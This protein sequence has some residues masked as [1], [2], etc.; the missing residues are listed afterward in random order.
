MHLKLKSMV[1]MINFSLQPYDFGI[2]CW[3]VHQSQHLLHPPALPQVQGDQ[4]LRDYPGH[5]LPCLPDY[6]Y[7]N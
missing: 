5:P 6:L 1:K 4:D 2:I 7:H 3:I